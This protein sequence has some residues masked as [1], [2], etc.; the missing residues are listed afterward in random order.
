MNGSCLYRIV[1]LTDFREKCDFERTGISYPVVALNSL[2]RAFVVV[3]AAVAL[4][5]KTSLDFL[6]V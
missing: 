2:L 5:W 1:Y 3:V 4:F 6:D